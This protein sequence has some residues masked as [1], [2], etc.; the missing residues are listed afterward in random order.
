MTKGASRLQGRRRECGVLDRL[1]KSAREAESRV[2]VLR[3]E[4]GVGKTALIEYLVEKAS[5]F[6]I[7]RATGVESEMEL[8]FAG[9]H[10]MCAPMLN[11]I[12]HL[13]DPQRDA[14]SVAFGMNTGDVP[15]RFLV[16]LAVLGLL[17]EVSEEQPLICVADDTQWLDRASAQ[18]LAFVS[19]R[20]LAERIALVFVV[21]GPIDELVGLPELVVG[22]LDDGDA[23]ALLASA[24]QGLLDERIRDRIVAETRGNPLALLELP[25]G[26]TP[27]ELAGGFGI[28]DALPL[29]SRIEESFLRRIRTL[30]EETQRLLLAAAAEPVGNVTL[31]WRA[32]ERLGIQADAAGPAEAEGLLELGARVRFRHPLVRSAAYRSASATDRQNAHRVLADVTDPIAE[33]DRRAWHLARAAKGPD[34]AVATELEQSAGRAQGRGGAAASAAFLQRATE[35]TPDP[36]QRGIRALAAAQSKF[37]AAAPDAASQLLDTAETCPL[38]DLQQARV[39]LLRAQIVFARRDTDAQRVLL[40][41]AKRLEPLDVLLARE[42]Y[43]EAFSASIYAGRLGSHRGTQ[44]IAEAARDAPAGPQPPRAV[45]LV[46]DGLAT[47]FS[48]SSLHSMTPL[49]HALDA[50]SRENPDGQNGIRWLWLMCPVTPE[51]LATELWDDQMWHELATRGVNLARDAGALAVLP[52]ALSYEAALRVHA[53]EFVA[54][55][56]SIEEAEAIT[57][58]VGV[59]PYSTSLLLLAGWRGQLD[60]T[61]ELFEQTLRDAEASG[62]GRAI[63]VAEYAAAVQYNGL[64]RYAD[65]VAAAQRAC[66][67]ED[68]GFYSWALIELVEAASRSGLSVLAS[69]ALTQLEQR[70]L[71]AGTDWALGILARSCALVSDDESAEELFKEAIA[72]LSRSRIVVHVSRAHLIYGEWLRR[73]D[74]R[75]EARGHLRG[76]H[77]MLSDIG[78]Q[79]FAERARRELAATGETVRKRAVD[80]RN[81]LTAQ[82]TQIAKLADEGS[83]NPQIA[84]RLFL[85]PRTV[86][87]HLGKVFTKLGI[88]SRRELGEALARIEPAHLT[89]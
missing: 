22:G 16:G 48:E 49:R 85:S 89:A 47:R 80:V 63:A 71:A 70:T 41:A 39:E 29:A 34:E 18:C 73:A 26:S 8:A 1:L 15:D 21:R 58:A 68:M 56:A 88:S 69:D 74:R 55:S 33:P 7:A 11:R 45:D 17:A 23:R 83:T 87:W 38:D 40:H 27:A 67:Y 6:R 32:A 57:V 79:A 76:A 75:V 51:P 25:R 14:L 44:E 36:T 13:P 19:R 59:T 31:L 12:E 46:V 10:Q 84:T 53:G 72:R 42:A 60:T 82:E 62:G 77:N 64:G 24:N 65:A 61:L 66:E 43:L 2:L 9:L 20:I 52:L 37:D 81:V 30:P 50:F 4:P 54:A 35:L 5:G 86:E 3:G 28:L 78:A